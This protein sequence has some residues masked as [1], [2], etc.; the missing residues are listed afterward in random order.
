MLGHAGMWLAQI[1]AG[2]ARPTVEAEQRVRA[3]AKAVD[4]DL[5]PVD[6]EFDDLIGFPFFRHGAPHFCFGVRT[7]KVCEKSARAR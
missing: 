7:V 5:M 2:Q 3:T 1:V 6:R 4:D